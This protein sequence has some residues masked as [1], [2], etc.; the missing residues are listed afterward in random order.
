MDRLYDPVTETCE[1]AEPHLFTHIHTT[2]AAVHEAKC[3]DDIEQ[4]MADKAL[5]PGMPVEVHIRTGDRSPPQLPGQAA[6]GLLFGVAAR[7]VKGPRGRVRH[8]QSGRGN[9]LPRHRKWEGIHLCG[10][11]APQFLV[12][13][14]KKKSILP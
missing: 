5:A 10:L 1:P 14:Y 7:G 12:L 6:Y 13:P 2:S 11:N 9:R 3:T 4:A 8:R